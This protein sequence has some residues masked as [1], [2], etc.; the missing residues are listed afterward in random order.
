MDDLYPDVTFL[1]TELEMATT[2][3]PTEYLELADS[4]YIRKGDEILLVGSKGGLVTFSWAP[5]N[6]QLCN[7][8]VIDLKDMIPDEIVRIRRSYVPY[9][10]PKVGA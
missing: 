8:K 10:D 6:A 4:Q 5:V 1:R 9:A 2:L 7:R 3:N